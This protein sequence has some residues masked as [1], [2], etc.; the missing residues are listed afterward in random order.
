VVTAGALI[1][2]GLWACAADAPT[3]T[4]AA[5]ASPAG[6][7]PAP[8][9]G[10]S[11][12]IVTRSLV[13]V[14]QQAEPGEAIGLRVALEDPRRQV[15]K[16][17]LGVRGVPEIE[18]KLNPAGE[19]VWTAQMN[20]PAM[21][22]PG[23]YTLELRVLGQQGQALAVVGPTTAQLEVVPAGRKHLAAEV[24]NK[25]DE[26]QDI[27][28][29]ELRDWRWNRGETP[30]AEQSAFDDSAWAVASPGISWGSENAMAWFRKEV[31]I[32]D[33]VA[34]F[35][36]TG[37]PVTLLVGVD[38][39]GEIYVNGTLRQKFHWD[40]GRVVL[41]EKAQ[42]GEKFL[43][44]IK[45]I[46][47]P[48]A[49][50]LFTAQLRIEALNDLRRDVGAYLGDLQ[51]GQSALGQIIVGGEPLRDALAKSAAAV[52]LKAL[53]AGDKAAFLGSLQAARAP[54]RPAAT[55]LKGYTLDLVGHAHI[56][57]NWLWLWPET[58]EV[59]RATFSQALDFM[60][61]FPDFTFSQSQASTYLAMEQSY[62]EIFA[63]I[64]Q[65]VKEGR[66][67]ITG[68][69]WVEGDMNMA[70]GEA[71][72]RQIL[73]AKRYFADKFG[74]DVRIAWEP[75]TFGHA[76]TVPQ[77]LR[78]AGISYYYFCRCGKDIPLFWWEAPD[79][80]RVLAY[81]WDGYSGDV[82]PSLG[83][84]PLQ[85][86]NDLRVTHAMQVYGVGDHGGGPTREMIDAA[87]ELQR[88]L[89]FPRVKFSTAQG[90]FDAITSEPT[91]LPV[92]RDELNFTFEGCYTTHADIKRMNRVS[93]NLLPTAEAFSA[94][95]A[96]WGR[97]YPRDDFVTAWRNTCFNQFHDIFDGSAI[98][99]SYDYARGLFDQAYKLG[100]DALSG[101]L[102]TLAAHIDTRGAG[103]ALIVFNP[104]AWDRSDA[105]TASVD[106]PPG[107]SHVRVTD[108]R[109]REVPAQ[110][111]PSESGAGRLQVCFTAAAPSLGYRVFHVAAAAASNPP[112]GARADD[113]GTIENEFWRL[114]VDPQNGLLTSIYDKRKQVELLPAGARANLFQALFE[115]PHGMSAWSIG[116][117]SRTENL[118]GPAQVKVVERGP[119]R[120]AIRV[121]RKWR[122]STFTQEVTLY[123]GVRRIDFITTADWRE[124]GTAA[125]DF[126]MIKVA[127]P[128][129]LSRA[130]ASFEIPYGS[131]VRPANGHEVPALKWIDL[132][133]VAPG[134]AEYGLSLLNDC[135]YGHDVNGN[136]LRLTL[137]RC[138]YDP[139]P[140]PD[141]GV[142]HFTYS[143]YPH[144]GGWRKALT[145]RQ[146]YELN[147]PL[148]ALAGGKADAGELP[149]SHS[150][151]RI[152][153]A[154]LVVTALKRAEDGDDLILRFYDAAGTAAQARIAPGFKWARASE[155]T[156]LEKP[157]EAPVKAAPGAGTGG[158]E[159]RLNVEPF[160]IKTVRMSRRPD[161]SGSR[162]K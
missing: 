63:A 51:F 117:I 148:I 84:L 101:A 60:K 28:G 120:A 87:L 91:E 103:A 96:A 104:V 151:L 80:S 17:S 59:C 65:R 73:Y 143:L 55:V 68:G 21:A 88:R 46:N 23:K 61:A 137:L 129:A 69:T 62:P 116:A 77:I 1:G 136:V 49:G 92:V 20:L 11:T 98:H 128:V 30:G 47:G 41:T 147:N 9:T 149:P 58:V 140:R 45:G 122:A 36:V 18:I 125:A 114:R 32:P 160:E 5:P 133:G 35:D 81:N 16:A 86:H 110:L 2:A 19:G 155:A 64:G 72:A 121:T 93:E 8:S 74:V 85:F 38:D 124:V 146:G 22:P 76:W 112:G 54:L 130:E 132:T 97:P 83:N 14:P 15:G 127:F 144:E 37:S 79:G 67:E 109:G 159:L 53:A 24:A 139:D 12:G 39:D 52:N 134:G 150:F 78:K 138:P 154:Q 33:K 66:W 111:V 157:T 90:F 44:A 106:L 113:S 145:V 126:P 89:I 6:A 108:D 70:S 95:A 142:H 115:K 152:E 131:I 10:P 153:P 34:G 50:E 135:K 29:L 102:E 107:T 56:D 31:V 3:P 13:I 82:N 40:E 119:A 75:D 42:P 161:E 25:L 71:I 105:V 43:I 57:M 26:L 141:E 27:L 118:D 48:G 158:D 99:G 4:A 162:A 156:L 123:A 7:A 94:I 100:A